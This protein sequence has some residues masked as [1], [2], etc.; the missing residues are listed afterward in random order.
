MKFNSKNFLIKPYQK[1]VEKPWGYEVLYTNEV[2][3]ATGKILH[4]YAGKR[5]SLQ[6]HDEKIETLCL[7]KGKGIIYLSDNTGKLV[8]I[9]MEP[10][11]GYLVVPGQHHRVQAITEM[12][13]IEASTPEKGN[14]YRIEDDAGRGTETEKVRQSENRGWQ[15]K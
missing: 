7:I 5:L 9:P 3:P 4:V 11:K 13:F 6:Y 14:T 2:A 8:N 12:E 10:F 15:K 1:R